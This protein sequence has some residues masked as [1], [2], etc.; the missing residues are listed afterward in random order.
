MSSWL[1]HAAATCL[2]RG[3]HRVQRGSGD[4]QRLR[5][6]R[7][8]EPLRHHRPRPSNALSIKRRLPAL[9]DA[10]G[11]GNGDA[12]AL[13]LRLACPIFVDDQV[14]KSSKLA[15][16]VSDKVNN[17]ELRRWLE[18]LNDEDLGRYKM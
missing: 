1:N 4:P 8:G 14:L 3:Q 6:L 15:A 2:L 5:Y 18:N 7:L 12:L 10:L 11:F 9:V 16:S 17:A 13:A